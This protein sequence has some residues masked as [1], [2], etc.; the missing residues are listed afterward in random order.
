MMVTIWLAVVLSLSA[1]TLAL[2]PREYAQA[3]QVI[4]GIALFIPFARLAGAP[5]ALQWNRHR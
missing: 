2:L 3:R 5:L 1:L 4:P